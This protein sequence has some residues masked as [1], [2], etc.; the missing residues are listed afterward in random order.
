V[1]ESL[2]KEGKV[3]RGYLGVRLLPQELNAALA[4][5]LGLPNN[6]GALVVDVQPGGPAERAGIKAGDVIVN[7]AQHE[8]VD[9]ADLRNVTAGL[10]VGG[11]VPVTFYREGKPQTVTVTIDEL[12][13][14]PE[15]LT[16]LGFNVRPGLTTPDNSGATIEVDR[17]IPGSPAFQAGLRHGMRIVAVGQEPVATVAQFEAAVRK[18]DTRGG[19]PL[20][21]QAQDGRVGPVL[22]GGN[23]ENKQP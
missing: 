5:N 7:V 21:V 13:P 17:V 10:D 2:I 19:L 8:V 16:A 14:A 20:F 15:V 6:R 12:P 9:R 18:L 3:V 11:Q 22:V 23:R 1:V 4:R